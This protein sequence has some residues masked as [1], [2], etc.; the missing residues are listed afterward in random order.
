MTDIRPGTH[1][2]YAAQLGGEQQRYVRG[3][4][5]AI[6]IYEDEHWV[7]EWIY[8]RWYSIDGRPDGGDTKHHRKELVCL[9]N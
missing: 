2:T 3:R 6:E 9:T 4:V 1:V 5:T 7:R 8:V